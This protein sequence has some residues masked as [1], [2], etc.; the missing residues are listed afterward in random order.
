MG[1]G[2]GI[3][4]ALPSLAVAT[5]E[6][7][8]TRGILVVLLLVG[9]VALTAGLRLLLGHRFGRADTASDA[10]PA[11]D[12]DRRDTDDA[13]DG[14]R[15]DWSLVLDTG[16]GDPI[17]VRRPRGRTCCVHTVRL[18][19]TVAL[20]HGPVVEEHL[21]WSGDRT[22]VTGN[23]VASE[24]HQ[25]LVTHQRVVEGLG[26]VTTVALARGPGP[27]IATPWTALPEGHSPAMD[28]ERLWAAHLDTLR[29]R[30]A[31]TRADGD[32]ASHAVEATDRCEVSIDVSRGCEG[33]HHVLH[34]RARTRVR[35]SASASGAATAR[36]TV[37][38]ST[39]WMSGDLGLAATTVV[40]SAGAVDVAMPDVPR[41]SLD[42]VDDPATVVL[43]DQADV[44]AEDG[45]LD[46]A[47][48]CDMDVGLV[49]G[50]PTDDV[51]EVRVEVRAEPT[52]VVR[53]VPVARDASHDLGCW[54]TPTYEL[55]FG[56]L[57][58]GQ[59]APSPAAQ[60]DV[61]GRR[62]HISRT[63]GPDLDGTPMWTVWDAGEH[64]DQ[65]LDHDS[66]GQAGRGPAAGR[67]GTGGGHVGDRDAGA[68]D[69]RPA[70]SP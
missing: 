20:G 29:E 7:A 32:P 48:G 12:T 21:A 59:S 69:P 14:P 17:V 67:G 36:V 25:D 66:V 70:G 35:I 22:R 65:G 38:G 53:V 34:A 13:T 40:S 5:T 19:S 37:D 57:P 39:A 56:E 51:A 50:P 55:R 61:E 64:D 54:C 33:G 62:F 9:L 31:R 58:P 10:P 41:V 6:A 43:V 2:G 3:G 28:Q 45:G 26:L 52:L 18:A 27:L 60:F 46:V 23:L 11:P 4:E 1:V 63:R 15:C 16:A 68:A 30:G 47:V 24:T 8:P 49:L 42:P 44:T